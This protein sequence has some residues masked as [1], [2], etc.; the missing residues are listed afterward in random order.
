LRSGLVRSLYLRNYISSFLNCKVWE[1][2]LLFGERNRFLHEL[3]V[4]LELIFLLN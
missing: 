4:N 1:V 3:I 2:I